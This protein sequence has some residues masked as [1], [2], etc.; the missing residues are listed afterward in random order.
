MTETQRMLAVGLYIN[1]A[2][3]LA[4]VYAAGMLE[5]VPH[6]WQLA[7][8]SAGVAYL[9]YSAQLAGVHRVVCAGLVAISAAAGLVAG[10][11][12]LV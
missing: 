1:A 12:L 7:L 5:H 8:V 6:A 10:I 11:V 2:L 9:S 3:Y 4:G